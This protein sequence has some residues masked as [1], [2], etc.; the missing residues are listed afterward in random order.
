LCFQR[1]ITSQHHPPVSLLLLSI[2]PSKRN[3]RHHAK[4]TRESRRTKP[5]LLQNTA[6]RLASGAVNAASNIASSAAAAVGYVHSHAEEHLHRSNLPPDAEAG[7][8]KKM[9]SDGLAV[10]EEA[11]VRHEV[12]VKLNKLAM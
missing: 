12:L 2:S 8:V 6:S 4:R 11:G 3:I 1:N 7:Q 10:F 5:S 9:D